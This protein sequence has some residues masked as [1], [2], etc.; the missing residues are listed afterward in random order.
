VFGQPEPADLIEM[1]VLSARTHPLRIAQRVAIV[2]LLLIP[3]L[4][5]WPQRG[6]TATYHANTE[7]RGDPVLHRVAT[8]LTAELAEEHRDTIPQQQFSLLM[9]GSL[10]IDAEGEYTFSTR[11][12]DGSTL[13]VAG[14]RVVDNG[15][16]HAARTASGRITLSRGLH[17]VRLR[18]IQGN[19]SYSLSVRWTPPGGEESDIPPS[20]LYVAAPDVPGLATIGRHVGT[21]WA[22]TWALFVL[23]LVTG[24]AR[25][26]RAPAAGRRVALRTALAAGS[27][28]L[29][30]LAVEVGMRVVNFVRE[31]RRPL[32]ERLAE[33]RAANDDNVR[34]Y[35]LGDIVQPSP[36]PGI[37]YE[38]KPNLRGAF[39]GQPL[40]TNSR[41]LRDVEYDYEKPAGTVRI[42][43]L[44]DSSLFG[45]GVRGEETTT[46]V[47]E[48]L[49][50]DAG[51]L[52]RTEVINF[53]A[54]G[55]N[56][57]IEADVLVEKALRY[58]PDIVLVNFNTNDYD[59]PA[60]MR[61]PQDYATLRRSFVF[62][63]VYSQYET[64]TGKPQRDLPVFEFD[65]RT[66][67]REQAD[68]LD[69]DPGL[70]DEY[71]YM[72][73]TRGFE[74]AMDRIVS[75]ARTAGAAVVV[76]DSRP[77]PGLHHTYVPNEFRDNQREL[78]E[79]LGRDKGLHWLNTY[80]Y[81]VEYLKA[82]PSADPL[83]VFAVGGGD[84]HPNALSH[85]ISAR[86]VYDYLIEK[87]LL[88]SN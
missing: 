76:Y 18:F 42:V 13:D 1:H 59:V 26:A 72:V 78:L 9:V 50:N 65:T 6:L 33:G 21:L 37:V 16:Y 7:W 48:R 3:L 60:F 39:Q 47:L 53:A 83:R 8:R 36:H 32:N 40:S 4:W 17:P 35:S 27:L 80:P 67:T 43:A 68:Q 54:P 22:G 57:A 14:T 58:D 23:L 30:V 75:A 2:A 11:S 81:Y 31:D 46:E 24:A 66:F 82:N 29:A 51:G 28:L 79:R 55:Y 61:L 56:T 45:W 71:R 84:T 63:L 85:G 10:R 44:G 5:I 86:A 52:P 70:P 19:G 62:D 74:R 38:V 25:T 77:F 64:W 88:A 15:G 20:V 41:G 12:D 87:K 73:G 34:V 69:K 49:V